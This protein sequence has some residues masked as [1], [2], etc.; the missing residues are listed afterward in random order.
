[1]GRASLVFYNKTV[2]KNNIIPE[3]RFKDS[4]AQIWQASRIKELRHPSHEKKVHY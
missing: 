1:M 4:V 3:I 2:L